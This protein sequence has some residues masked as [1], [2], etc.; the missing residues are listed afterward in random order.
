MSR[1]WMTCALVLV[2]APVGCEAVQ[3]VGE[4]LGAPEQTKALEDAAN[5]AL[6][7][8]WSGAI[9][10]V[11]GIGIGAVAIL[12]GAKKLTKKVPA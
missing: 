7:G 12:L 10:K 9:L 4:W 6:T 11:A 1:F 2:A 8:N 3:K 5:D